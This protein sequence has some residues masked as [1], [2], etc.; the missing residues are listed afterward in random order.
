MADEQGRDSAFAYRCERGFGNFHPQRRVKAGK[1]LV[2]QNGCGTCCKCA[3]NRNTLLL[4]TGQLVGIGMRPRLQPQ[5]RKPACRLAVGVVS[6]Q[7][8]QPEADI[9]KG[10]HVREQREI[11]KDEAGAPLLGRECPARPGEKRVTDP[12]LAFIDRFEPCKQAQQG[13]FAS[14]RRPD[15]GENA[16]RLKGEA[17]A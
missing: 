17:G 15:K 5:T 4:T 6:R 2:H 13:R 11:L 12:Y 16:A 7:A 3:G 1:R 9:A 14:P 8:G 10:G